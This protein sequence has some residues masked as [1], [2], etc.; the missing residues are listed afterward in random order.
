[1][2]KFTK[3][4]LFG[5]AAGAIGGLLAAPRSGKETRKKVIE[6]I[7]EFT[8]LKNEVSGHRQEVQAATERLKAT[9]NA[10]LP[11]FIEG[12]KQDLTDF[13]FQAEPRIQQIKEQIAKINAQLPELP[14]ENK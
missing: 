2:K 11:P 5:A 3:G 14:K 1:M 6:E 4:L 10:L 12:V 13:Q 7:E 8:Y 9:A